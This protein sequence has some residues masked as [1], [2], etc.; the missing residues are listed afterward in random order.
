MCNSKFM[1][2]QLNKR[3]SDNIFLLAI[4]IYRDHL[5]RKLAIVS[6]SSKL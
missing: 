2:A 3:S 4:V 6:E 5:D 1:Y